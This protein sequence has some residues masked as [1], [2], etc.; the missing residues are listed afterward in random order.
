M[1]TVLG[2]T[3]SGT[4]VLFTYT[5]SSSEFLSVFTSALSFVTVNVVVPFP[6]T[7]IPG[8]IPFMFNVSFP[9]SCGFVSVIVIKSRPC[10]ALN[11]DVAPVDAASKN[12]ALFEHP[13][14]LILIA[15][16]PV[17]FVSSSLIYGTGAKSNVK[18][19]PEAAS[20]PS[21]T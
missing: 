12:S 6:D 8:N 3:I 14:T 10:G 13:G 16:A 19:S 20:V 11:I 9:A 4:A 2:V 1:S 18:G 21:V 5:K 7:E 15:P 17:L